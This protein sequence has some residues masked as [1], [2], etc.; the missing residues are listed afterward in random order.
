MSFFSTRC[1][2]FA[3]KGYK[4]HHVKVSATRYK[5]AIQFYVKVEVGGCSTVTM[6]AISKPW[7]GDTIL[8]GNVEQCN[9]V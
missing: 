7:T 2:P 8:S 5:V 4:N 9:I 3:K 6:A 1:R